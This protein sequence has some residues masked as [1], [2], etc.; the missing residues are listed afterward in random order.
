MI[1]VVM[2]ISALAILTA[3]GN[4]VANVHEQT[5]DS[6]AAAPAT[7]TEVTL[8]DDRL[9]AIFRHYRLL[10]EALINEDGAAAR[11]AANAIAAGA[12]G[13]SGQEAIQAAAAKITATPD[14]AQ[15]RDHYAA[16]SNQLINRIKA[17]GINT[18]A[19][20]IDFCP[21]AMNDKGASWLSTEKA[22]VNPFFGEKMKTCGEVKETIR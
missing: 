13:V 20:Y 21:M 4:K 12:A 15:Q 5:K 2:F 17:T 14:I 22:I 8:K 16:L 9:N 18:G 10:T 1:K 3:C 7:S 6:L 19:L 11:K